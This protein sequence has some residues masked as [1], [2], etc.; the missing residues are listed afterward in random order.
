V[1][2]IG[3]YLW[4]TSYPLAS[5]QVGLLKEP[6]AVNGA[7]ISNSTATLNPLSLTYCIPPD[8]H[9]TIYI[10]V[11][12]NNSAPEEISYY[13]QSLD[14]G[15]KDIRTIAGSAMKRS[16]NANAKSRLEITEGD[17]DNDSD[18][19]F[20][21][22]SALVLHSSQSQE[23]DVAK[24]PSVKPSDSLALVPKHLEPTQDILFLTADKPSIIMLKNVIDKRG[25]R[26]HIA[27][28]REAVIVEC[29]TGGHFV[30]DHQ[31]RIVQ[32]GDKPQ[33]AELRCVGEEEVA[34]F[35]ARG[36]APLQVGWRKKSK[37]AS[38]TGVIEGIED[39]IDLAEQETDY[40]HRVSKTHTVPLRLTHGRP[41]VYTVSLTGVT[42]SLHNTYTPSGH[43]AEKVFNVIA[44]SSARFDCS[45]PI[46]LLKDRTATLPVLLDGS[47]QLPP[48]LEVQYGHTS[49][50]GRTI[51]KSLKMTKRVEHV[52]VSEPGTYTLLDIQGPCAGSVM[53]PSTCVV[54]MVP[55]PTVDMTVTT[56][57]E[58]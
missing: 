5:I 14:T 44:R 57:H 9:Q 27:P 23:L 28:H 39:E 17:E 12:F 7:D 33:P 6:R 54:Q 15:H 11:V 40:R 31:D 43:S 37:D 26:F 42:D 49:P 52:V 21:P 29:P 48:S 19:E 24:L 45:A 36:V 25:D 2:G 50:E 56:L 16:T 30:E 41:G 18:P 32:K 53:E 1:E 46:Q 38:E 22:L 3:A 55:L 20:D 58:W 47:G 13:V 35:Q 8:S 4:D 10:P 51:T 34:K